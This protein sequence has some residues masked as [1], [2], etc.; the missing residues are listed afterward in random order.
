MTKVMTPAELVAATFNESTTCFTV[1]DGIQVPDYRTVV[2][3]VLNENGSKKIY[4]FSRPNQLYKGVNHII[5][6]YTKPVD[7][8][9]YNPSTGKNWKQYDNDGFDKRVK[10]LAREL[11]KTNYQVHH[12]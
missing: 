7:A 1:K 6:S 5:E 12:I 3:T 10:K 4:R 2:I 8:T 11:R 9:W